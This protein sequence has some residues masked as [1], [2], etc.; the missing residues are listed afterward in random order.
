MEA[1]LPDNTA[2]DRSM[3]EPRLTRTGVA[4]VVG[5]VHMG[6]GA[7][8]RAFNAI[9][10]EQAMAAARSAV[11]AAKRDLGERGPVWWDDGA[12]DEGRMAPWNSSYAEWWDGLDEEAK[13]RG[14]PTG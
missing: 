7:F 4:P 2:P 6:P 5:I 9:Y 10:T 8:F 13:A 14:N 1:G 11:D 3:T 12:A